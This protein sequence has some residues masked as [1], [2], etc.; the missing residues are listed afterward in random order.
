V[1]RDRLVWDPEALI[2]KETH[3]RDPRASEASCEYDVLESFGDTSLIKVRLVTGKRNQIRLQAR[4]RGHTLVG[5]QRYV[6]GP[7]AIRHIEFPRQ[8]LHAW[9][10]GIVHPAAG[11]PMQFEAPLPEDMDG[12]ISELEDGNSN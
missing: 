7:Q 2:Q 9:R 8:A 11:K 12:L 6:Y 4:L 1:W 5:E 3:A 10:L